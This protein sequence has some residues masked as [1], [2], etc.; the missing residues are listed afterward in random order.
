M[1]VETD[2][3]LIGQEPRRPVA[4]L[5]GILE[6]LARVPAGARFEEV[7]CELGQVRVGIVSVQLLERVSD[8]R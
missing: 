8:R 3:L 2:G 6:G 1:P 4:R 5:A 7:V